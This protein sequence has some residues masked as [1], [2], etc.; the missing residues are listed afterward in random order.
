MRKLTAEELKR[1]GMEIMSE[2][3]IVAERLSK[4]IMIKK[5]FILSTASKSIVDEL[6][7][8]TYMIIKEVLIDGREP[9]EVFSKSYFCNEDDSIL[10]DVFNKQIFYLLKHGEGRAMVTAS[11]RTMD[12]I[13]NAT[14]RDS[15]DFI[16]YV[17][18]HILRE[19]VKDGKEEGNSTCGAKE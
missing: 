14:M 2:M 16:L 6:I 12:K 4:E 5:E 9:L 17:A 10:L 7:P 15:Y 8:K 11:V 18:L 1:I 19:M 3:S 13:L